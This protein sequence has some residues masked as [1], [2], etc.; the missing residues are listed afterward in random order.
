MEAQWEVV[1]DHPVRPIPRYGYQK[2]PH[3]KLHAL[4]SRNRS[5]Y[6][7]LL[8]GFLT[9]QAPLLRIEVDEP[10]SEQD[11]WWK[12]G[13]L[14]GMDIMPLYCWTCD[15]EPKWY[16]EIGSGCSTKFVRRAIR[17]FGLR[18]RILSVDPQPRDEVDGICDVVVREPLEDLDLAVFGELE[19]GDVVFVDGSHRCFTN[20][21]ATVTFLDVIPELPPGV[22][23][24]IHDV[25]LPCD[26]PPGWEDRFYSEQYLLAAFLLAEGSKTE[27]FFPCS[28]VSGEHDLAAIVAE[29]WDAPGMEGVEVAGSTFWLRT[30]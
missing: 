4:I 11:P 16:F 22:L 15:L 10:A 19:E 13:W 18:T 3:P 8:Q 12:C 20:S 27:V 6:E 17:D 7:S 1:L 29:I 24:G 23:V 30:R 28:F 25:Y 21:D 9:Y 14:G 5:L 2:P 26:Y